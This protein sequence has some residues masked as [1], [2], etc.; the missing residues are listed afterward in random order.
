MLFLLVGIREIELFIN[1]FLLAVL[2]R[3]TKADF[4]NNLIIPS[5]WQYNQ[6]YGSIELFHTYRSKIL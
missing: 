1:R 2:K 3:K 6:I 5:L 4:L